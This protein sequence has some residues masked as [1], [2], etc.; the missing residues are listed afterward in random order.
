MATLDYDVYYEATT[1]Q[2][3]AEIFDCE[4]GEVCWHSIAMASEMVCEQVALEH[5]RQLEGN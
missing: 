5:L 3:Y 2:Y 1:A 4:T